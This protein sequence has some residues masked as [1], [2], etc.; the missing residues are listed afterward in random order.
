MMKTIVV[1]RSKTGYTKKYAEWIAEELHCDIKENA[2]YKDIA[3]YDT[4][5]FG[6]GI[7]AG[8]IN[9]IKLITAN[10]ERLRRKNIV[11]FAVGALS[12][13]ENDMSGIWQRVFD[14]EQLKNTA[15]FYFR[16]GFDPDRLRGADKLIIKLLISRLKK[17]ADPTEK[18][19]NM[20]AQFDK[21]VD[22]TDRENIYPLTEY[23][24]S[25]ERQ[26]QQ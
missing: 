1:Y 20:L 10:Y 21:A 26:S 13:S 5:I 2:S 22:N 4:I 12:E 7:Y 19:R 6:G 24:Q 16:G 18:E 17:S 15:R 23:I 3:E 11:I 8:G 9:G 14:S 25:K